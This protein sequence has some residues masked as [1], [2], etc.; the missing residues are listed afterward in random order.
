MDTNQQNQ[1]TKTAQS[2]EAARQQPGQ[3]ESRTGQSS[4]DNRQ[5]DP[6][7]QAGGTGA[8][9]RAGRP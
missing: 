7:R 1:Q 2:G 3:A 5:G 9:R 4:Q 6:G 8:A